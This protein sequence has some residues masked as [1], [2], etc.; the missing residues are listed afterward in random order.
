MRR[1]V[2]FGI[3]SKF[4]LLVVGAILA[5]TA[6]T[7]ALTVRKEN[8]A[9]YETLLLDGAAL[10][11]MTAQNCEYAVYTASR[12]TLE[13]IGRALSAYPAVAYVRVVDLQG[14][15]LIEKSF[16]EGIVIPALTQ[17]GREVAGTLARA[18]D[19]SNAGDDR[20]YLDLFVPVK[21]TGG[22]DES[23]LFEAGPAGGAGENEAIGFLQMGLGQEEMLQR[24]RAF[25]FHAA[26]S[27]LICVVLGIGFTMALTRA[28]TAPIH[29]LVAA[30]GAVAEGRLDQGIEVRTSD[31]LHELAASFDGM[32]QRLREYRSEVESYRRGLEEK[33]A[34]RT[35]QLAEATQR[36]YQLAHKAEEASQAKSRFLANMSHEIRTPMNGVIGMTE[37]LLETELSERQR[38]FAETVRT[39]ADALLDIINDILDFSK[40]E[41]GRMVLETADFDVRQTVEGVGQLL[42]E[43]A[44][45]KGLELTL[46][47]DGDVATEVIGDPGR[48]RQ[49]LINLIGNAIKFT[50][51]GEVAVRVSAVE[52]HPE[53]SVLRFE[54]R[55]TGIGV[56][57]E[58]RARIFEAF[59]QADES[60]TRRYGGTGL[61]LA[62]A[63][64]LTEMMGGSLGLE[65]EPGKGS[66][67]H[68]TARF[69]RHATAPPTSPPRASLRGLRVAIVD[70]NDTNREVLMH[71]V[72]AWGMREGCAADGPA[73]LELLRAAAARGEPFDIAILDMMMPGMTGLDLARAVKA[74]PAIAPLHMV[75]LTSIGLRGDALDARRAG[76]AG[77]LA[78]PVRQSELY[79]CIAT[80]IGRREHE[81]ALV[82][83]HSLSEARAR[84]QARVLLVEDNEVNRDVERAM[85]EI[86][87]CSVEAA[88][89]GVEALDRLEGSAYDLVLMDC[90]MPE[91]DGFEATAAIRRREA[92]SQ[93]P[94]RAVI[95]ALTAH[96]LKE[97]RDRCLAAGMDDYLSKPLRKEDLEACLDRWCRPRK[98]EAVASGPARTPHTPSPTAA[99]EDDAV[100]TKVLEQLRL[101]QRAGA[102][103]IVKKTVHT[104][105]RSSR[106]LMSDLHESLGRGD[107]PVARRAAHSLKSSSAVVGAARLSALC[108]ELEALGKENA[109]AAAAERLAKLDHEYGRV[110]RALEASWGTEES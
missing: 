66:T 90:Q 53:A 45:S 60:M 82:T 4:N 37:L 57:P 101:L 96:A 39:S 105:L 10:A 29:S 25:V 14:Q 20:R 1:P 70:D 85:L 84:F 59:T 48:L 89:N 17:K 38:R 97:D 33:V 108:Q 74:D 87:G 69:G 55:D 49:I 65:S 34:Q 110:R 3:G 24:T 22:G 46:R 26:L 54:V 109:L 83:R 27:A 100:D 99:I 63:R 72:R 107:A 50:P 78:K 77:Y 2:R 91:M 68:F 9:N 42:A 44:H 106:L 81:T 58:A 102:P 13:Q 75:I 28:I 51:Q 5:T 52:Q 18:T 35:Q 47:V 92:E 30:T 7:G 6:G 12:E 64:Q 36:A 79:D 95:I 76:V 8:L 103:D 62:I 93:G 11:Q 43:R 31:E 94:R 16:R 88:V 41:A 23:M 32:L 86:L 67:F 71:Q 21:G 19:V 56:S 40:I 61:G 104:F 15:V 80:V 73:A 98:D